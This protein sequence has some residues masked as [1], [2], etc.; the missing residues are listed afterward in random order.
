METQPWVCTGIRL[1]G[2]GVGQ[3]R[4]GPNLPPA[5]DSGQTQVCTQAGWGNGGGAATG[6][7]PTYIG[8]W[9]HRAR[10][11]NVCGYGGVGVGGKQT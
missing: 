6:L 10:V 5:V 3:H 8:G 4:Q 9:T 7:Q 11:H 1:V 2:V